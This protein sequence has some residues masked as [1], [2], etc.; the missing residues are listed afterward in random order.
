M[1]A[2]QSQ[3]DG[4]GALK[5][6]RSISNCKHLYTKIELLQDGYW[7]EIRNE[8]GIAIGACSSGTS[9]KCKDS[10]PYQW[11][12]TFTVTSAPITGTYATASFA[13]ATTAHDDYDGTDKVESVFQLRAITRDKWSRD[14]SNPV[15]QAFTVTINYECQSDFFAYKAGQVSV[16]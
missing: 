14:A 11:L 16:G 9:G 2:D 3:I 12:K 7:Q 10:A 4:L 5:T 15:S 8:G 1:L 13:V 6:A